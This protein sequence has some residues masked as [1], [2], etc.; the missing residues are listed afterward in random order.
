MLDSSVTKYTETFVNCYQL[1][2]ELL[3]SSGAYVAGVSSVE[4]L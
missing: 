2:P 3:S 4:I 1:L